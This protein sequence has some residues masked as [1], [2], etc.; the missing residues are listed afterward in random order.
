MTCP[1]HSMTSPSTPGPREGP[2]RSS[3]DGRAAD[4]AGSVRLGTSAR[5]RDLDRH[6]L[7]STMGSSAREKA[8]GRSDVVSEGV[9]V[10]AHR[11]TMTQA[12]KRRPFGGGTR[13]PAHRRRKS[14]GLRGLG[15][16]PGAAPTQPR[17]VAAEASPALWVT[18]RSGVRCSGA[19]GR[20]AGHVWTGRSWKIWFAASILRKATLILHSLRRTTAR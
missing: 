14:H 1:V 4:V 15:L 9:G 2:G 20:Q 17:P 8:G 7:A 12:L 16:H 11:R 18:P 13:D 10:V 5:V 6:A 3:P 19:C